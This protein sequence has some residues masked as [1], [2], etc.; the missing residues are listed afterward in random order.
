[1]GAIAARGSDHLNPS[2]PPRTPFKLLAK[3]ETYTP[4]TFE[5]DTT[6]RPN[7]WLDVFRRDT[8]SFEAR[9]ELVDANAASFFGHAFERCLDELE[10][11]G[12]IVNVVFLCRLREECLRAAGFSDIFAHV[13]AEEN[14]NALALLPVAL[15]AMDALANP[16][17]R[18]KR[19]VFGVFAGNIFDL[20]AAASIERFKANNPSED[21]LE[22]CSELLGASEDRLIGASDCAAFVDR[23]LAARRI[24]IFVDNAGADI[25]L[26]I[27]PLARELL[28]N[29]PETR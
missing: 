8:A 1:M 6:A 10:L 22:T 11:Q 18:L 9:A 12:S 28:R 20:G 23:A 3:P 5:A 27:I 16:L 17:E 21:F 25:V 14:A 7:V 24:L 13:K 4:C 26:G 19:A 15:E 29:N 2:R